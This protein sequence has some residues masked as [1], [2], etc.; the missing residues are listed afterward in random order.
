M[1]ST[2][3]QQTYVDAQGNGG[4]SLNEFFLCCN[5]LMEIL[6]GLLIEFNHGGF[7]LQILLFRSTVLCY[8]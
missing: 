3:Y 1:L 7:F 8:V 4:L 5:P 2:G 6:L